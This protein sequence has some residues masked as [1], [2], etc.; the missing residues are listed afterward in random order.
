M[1]LLRVG[2]RGAERPCLMD[3]TGT[4]RDLSGRVPDLAGEGLSRDALDAIRALDHAGLPVLEAPARVGPCLAWVPT[5]HCVGLN[6]AKHAA[7]TGSAV[8][9][10]PVL[11][12]KAA[13]ALSGPHDDIPLPRGSQS[14]DWEVEL[15]VVIGKRAHA[16]PEADA[17]AHVAGYC[18]VNDISERDFQKNRGGQFIKGKSSPG[19]GPV[20]PWL[21]TADEVPDPQALALRLSVD[22]EV[23]QDSTTADMVMPV[24]GLIAYISQFM[25]LVPGDIIATGTPEGV[26]L[27]MRPPRFL[28]RG[29]TVEAEVAGLG[30]QK[31]RVV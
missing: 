16:V 9:A 10:E 18:T 13:S 21:V 28:R 5:F 24:A 20:G 30:R 25:A 22:G 26:G 23:M 14:T 2:P 19:F 11:F 15:G 4:L 31:A 7:E 29:Q 6:Y 27:G 17:L 8:P 1:K 3:A 12:S